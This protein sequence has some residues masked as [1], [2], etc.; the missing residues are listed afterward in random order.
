MRAFNVDELYRVSRFLEGD[1]AAVYGFF[2]C[3]EAIDYDV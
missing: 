2:V 3:S 1:E